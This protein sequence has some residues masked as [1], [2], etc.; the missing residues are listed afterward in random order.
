MNSPRRRKSSPNLIGCHS[1]EGISRKKV[2]SN[3]DESS[4]RSFAVLPAF[5]PRLLGLLAWIIKTCP[6]RTDQLFDTVSFATFPRP[7]SE[8]CLLHRD[9]GQFLAGFRYQRVH[10][11]YSKKN[12]RVKTRTQKRDTKGNRTRHG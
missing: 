8:F 4:V 9:R 10:F 2:I 3:R 11:Q 7:A 1:Y 12:E 5:F 6:L